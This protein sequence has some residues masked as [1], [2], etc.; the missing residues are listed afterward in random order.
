MGFVYENYSSVEKFDVDFGFAEIHATGKGSAV[1]IFKLRDSEKWALQHL[2]PKMQSIGEAVV[3]N[4]PQD[5]HS[6]TVHFEDDGSFKLFALRNDGLADARIV[7]GE[8]ASD[9]SSSRT[10]Q[11]IILD[12]PARYLDIIP[13]SDGGY[14][15]SFALRKDGGGYQFYLQS[16]DPNLTASGSPV[17][18][19]DVPGLVGGIVFIAGHSL[20]ER[21]DGTV[22]VIVE[23]ERA[24]DTWPSSINLETVVLDADLSIVRPVSPVDPVELTENGT[25]WKKLTDDSVLFCWS[26]REGLAWVQLDA[27]GSV[28][29]R[30]AAPVESG[31][32]QRP[33]DIFQMDNGSFVI[34]ANHKE[35]GFLSKLAYHFQPDGTQ[36][37]EAIMLAPPVPWDYAKQ[38]SAGLV[39][40]EPGELFSYWTQTASLQRY[41]PA[42]ESYLVIQELAERMD[43]STK[44]GLDV[45]EDVRMRGTQAE[46]L[47][48]LA[49]GDDYYDAMTGDDIVNAGYG[50]DTVNGQGGSDNLFGEAGDDSLSGGSQADSLHGGTGND[51]LDGGEGA[52]RMIG[53]PGS[54]TYY[55]DDLDDLIGESRN[56]DGHDLVYSSV[57]FRMG[58]CHIEDLYLTDSAVVGSGNGLAN[59]IRGN[60][61]D[62]IIDGGKNNDTMLGGA[63][64]DTYIV[65]APGDTVIEAAGRGLADT[66]KAY[67]SYA[68]TENVERLF[69]QTV[70]TKDGDPAILNGVGNGLANT[71]I[72]TPFAN[73]IVGRE[74]RDTLK[75]QAGADIF[76]FDRTI[77][78]NN[79][80]RVIDFNV[81]EVDEGDILKLKASEFGNIAAGV[82]DADF[83]V[84][85]TSA[86]DSN[87]YLIFDQSSGRLWFDRDGSGAAEQ[88]LVATFEQNALVTA[89]DI[90]VF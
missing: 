4:F 50:S 85:G 41:G 66:V 23:H 37:G 56:W 31:S 21:S 22:Q 39:E 60:R 44:I 55:V 32:R 10:I 48:W 67:R 6:V 82:L 12:H 25:I 15:A 45:G 40:L 65:R 58:R 86:N 83:F 17:L 64:N 19:L 8:F 38:S 28:L 77:G 13:R 3:L 7:V 74:G 2:D 57:D 46:D 34:T 18:A 88:Q 9:G 87:D 42:S 90:F 52:D 54:D 71:I 89:A 29:A 70:F 73:T 76:V 63:G 53:G 1:A 35:S 30:G 5:I 20:H 78:P 36:I 72:G 47:A 84:L 33:D 80:D 61:E 16:F 27:A 43:L 26:T 51:T 75:G 24:Y 68:L 59:E 79:V 49:G 81:N 14:I 69:M 62:N 11:E